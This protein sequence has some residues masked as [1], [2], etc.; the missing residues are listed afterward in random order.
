MIRQHPEAT[1]EVHPG[2]FVSNRA[3]DD[4]EPDP[5]VGGESHTLVR[6]PDAYAGMTRYDVAPEPTPWT[7][8]ERETFLILEGAAR[9]EI[10]GGPT[11]ELGAGDMASLPKGTVTT[12]HITAPFQEMWFF[13]RPYDVEPE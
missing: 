4:W 7:L 6:E 10:A 3:T 8:P 11:L 9:I 5:E 2:V 13:G 12:W 1:V